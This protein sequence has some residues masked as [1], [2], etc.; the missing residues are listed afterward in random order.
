MAGSDDDFSDLELDDDMDG[1]AF[2]QTSSLCSASN[3]SPTS[4]THSPPTSPSPPNSTQSR[5]RYSPRWVDCT[6]EACDHH[7]VYCSCRPHCE[8][9]RVTTGGLWTVS[10]TRPA[11]DDRVTDVHSRSQEKSA[12]HNGHITVDKLKA[13]LGFSIL[14]GIDQ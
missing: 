7:S 9:S 11:G 10:H 14:M 4:P 13:F 5:L 12:T 8:Y 3:S 1:D 2:E 6:T